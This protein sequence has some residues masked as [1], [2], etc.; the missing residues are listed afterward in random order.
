VGDEVILSDVYQMAVRD[1]RQITGAL[2]PPARDRI[3]ALC[4]GVDRLMVERWGWLLGEERALGASFWGSLAWGGEHYGF[5]S[6]VFV[7][8]TSARSDG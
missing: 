1:A 7:P 8:S 3:Q 4:F 2:L 6:V 5:P